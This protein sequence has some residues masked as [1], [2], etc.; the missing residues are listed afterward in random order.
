MRSNRTDSLRTL[1]DLLHSLRNAL[2]VISGHSQYL[3]GQ[4]PAQKLCGDELRVIRRAAERAARELVLVPE[5]IVGVPLSS[6]P[7]ASHSAG[8]SR[9]RAEMAV[10]SKS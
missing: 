6:P 4:S 2:S 1:R 10:R 5:S 9:S 7:A 3:L 8:H